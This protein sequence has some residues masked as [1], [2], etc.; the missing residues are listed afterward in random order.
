MN[1]IANPRSAYFDAIADQ[2]DAWDDLG[3]LRR[4][5][6]DGLAG[7]GLGRQETVL[8][9]GCGTG[10]LTLALLDAL[11]DGGRVHAVDISPRMLEVARAKVQDARAAFHLASAESLPLGDSSCDRII[12]FSVWPHL[13]DAAAVGREFLRVLRR[14]G[15]VHVWHQASRQ[16]INA[17]HAGAGAAVAG[18]LLPPAAQTAASLA[19]A[20][21]QVT[22]TVD[23]RERYLVTAGKPSE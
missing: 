21:F 22:A 15:Q 16:T 3:A 17:I 18:D 6:L 4:R 9:V 2:W 23:D 1:A 14:G 7:F 13:R 5:L 20:G 19:H 11:G 8:D 10:N 12:C